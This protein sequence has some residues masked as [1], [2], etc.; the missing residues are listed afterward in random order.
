MALKGL[1][2][3]WTQL[4]KSGHTETFK[5]TNETKCGMEEKKPL[6]YPRIMI[7]TQKV[8]DLCLMENTKRLK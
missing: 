1:I 7:Q 4:K 6:E 3:Y 8:Y 2:A 5:A